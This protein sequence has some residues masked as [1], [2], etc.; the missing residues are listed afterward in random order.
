[1]TA[2]VA[3]LDLGAKVVIDHLEELETRARHGD[4]N[5]WPEYLHS[6]E[7]LAAISP[8]LL[9]PERRGAL[10]TTEQM[11]ERYGITSKTLLKHKKRGAV[12]P[13]IAR[14]KFIRW[15]GDEIAR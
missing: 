11:A 8:V 14:G 6:L 7:V 3:A 10:L 4:E 15:R 13:T 12:R 5:A 9:T 1:V 2:L